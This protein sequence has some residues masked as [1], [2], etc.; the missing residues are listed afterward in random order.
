VDGRITFERHDLAVTFPEGRFDLVAAS[1]FQ[2]PVDFPRA[3][4]LARAARAVASGGHLFII[5]HGSR[6]PWSWAS[7]DTYFPTVEETLASL[8]LDEAEWERICVEAMEREA[9]GPKGETAMLD[10][11]V[12]FLRR[13]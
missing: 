9:T 5:E 11:N 12:I 8:E 2:S 10:D 4:V 3:A 7:A 6:A 1:F 13:R